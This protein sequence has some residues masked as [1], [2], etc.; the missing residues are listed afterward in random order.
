MSHYSPQLSLA[1]A[2]EAEVHIRVNKPSCLDSKI[3]SCSCRLDPD[4]SHPISPRSTARTTLCFQ[5][6]YELRFSAPIGTVT[7]LGSEGSCGEFVCQTE[8]PERL[9]VPS[10]FSSSLPGS[11]KL[12]PMPT[13][14]FPQPPYSGPF[15]S[16]FRCRLEITSVVHVRG[17]FNALQGRRPALLGVGCI[18]RQ[19]EW[20][21]STS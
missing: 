12:R 11:P 19:D 7:V 4:H 9:P 16:I 6:S 1:F 17:S 10:L 20:V 8:W 21:L 15:P 2:V 3:S 13:A 14:P 18:G 5:C